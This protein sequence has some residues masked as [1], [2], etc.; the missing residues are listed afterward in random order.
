MS[1][2]TGIGKNGQTLEIQEAVEGCDR[3]HLYTK[4]DKCLKCLFNNYQF[5]NIYKIY[6]SIGKS[7][8]SYSTSKE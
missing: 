7:Q 4:K 1:N 2:R 5:L 8:F 6:T 3:I